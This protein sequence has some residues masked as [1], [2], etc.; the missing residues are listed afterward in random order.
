MIENSSDKEK[1]I[2]TSIRLFL[3][4]YRNP[5]S[6]EEHL[7]AADVNSMMWLSGVTCFLEIVFLI[8]FLIKYVA[9]GIYTTS[10]EIIHYS[11]GYIILCISS[12]LLHI[13]CLEYKKGRLKYIK[14]FS[15]VFAFLYIIIGI[16]FGIITTL[17]DIHKGRMI[18]CF[19]S[20][21]LFLTL[22]F[23]YRPY[24]S[25]LLISFFGLGFIYIVNHYA[26]DIN[27]N[28]YHMETGDLLNFLTF[29]ICMIILVLSLYFQ[30]YNDAKNEYQMEIITESLIKKHQEAHEQFEQ[31]A[32]ALANTIDAKDTY[33]NGHS[34]RVADYSRRIAEV[35]GKSEEE[36]ERV[37]FAALLHDV[38]KIGVPNEILSKTTKLTEE[39]FEC[40]KKHP[41][42]G[43]QIL[44]SIRNSPWLSI[45]AHYHH[46]RYDGKGYPDGLKGEE[47]PEI[48]RIIAV[49]DAYDAMTS[50]RC[51]RD[52]I[53]QHIVREEL[54][55][56]MRLQFDPNIARIMIQL[57]DLDTEYKMKEYISGANASKMNVLHCETIYTGC[58]DGIA[59]TRK[60]NKVKFF[61][62]PD[63]GYK[64]NECLP[65]FIIYDSLDG[66]VHP[67]E[68][69][70]K[71][72]LY[73]EYAKIK[74]DGT[75][76]D[77]GIRKSEVIVHKNK[78]RFDNLH[79][80][81]PI[82]E[83]YYTVETV[84]N[85]DHVLLCI[86]TPNMT[87]DVILALP[88]TSRYAYLSIS[89][90]HCVLH[91]IKVDTDETKVPIDYIPRIAEEISYIKDCPVGDIPNIQ[92]D[93]PRFSTSEGIAIRDEMVISFHTKSY[94]TSRLVWHCPYICL[95]TSLNGQVDG[96]DFK[97]FI[98]LK[99]YGENWESNEN[100]K[101]IVEVSYNDEFKGWDSWIEKNKA[102]YDC[103]VRIKKD[104]N[105][106]H[107]QTNNFGISISS[108]TTIYDDID[109][110]YIAL[111]GDQCAIT[112]IHVN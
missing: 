108:L 41:E 78:N 5:P 76:T 33:T 104:Q 59:I 67:G 52:A 80:N 88:D 101:N 106:I 72:L 79:L 97:E 61:S 82:Q 51:Y 38:G 111:T 96:E 37:Y 2:W 39:E 70:N 69:K 8:R 103:I 35:L 64:E 55:K 95:F 57:I 63:Y 7:K 73:F 75:V 85:R 65:T 89:G 6:I 110:L 48:A 71:D 13:Y 25:I 109:D 19:L 47:I 40:I 53:P 4:F 30:R 3:G 92:A 11:Y 42:V 84:R 105:K 18:T 14:K 99:I 23:I 26:V 22:I 107:I 45:G 93:G 98:L 112:N 102:G 90:E 17:S 28:Q 50:N 24:M 56:G 91:N 100:A 20:M 1:S 74:V 87:F 46:E 21:F 32:E 29:T 9:S 66:N 10:D 81:I 16:Y 58:T 12:L 54:V 62:Q 60:K 86:S 27:G 94:P 44:S 43:S 77:K 31:T 36:C 68:D 83:N 49:V 34:R 15:R